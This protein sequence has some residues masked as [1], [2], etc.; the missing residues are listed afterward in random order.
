MRQPALVHG[1]QNQDQHH[2]FQERAD[3]ALSGLPEIAKGGEQM[4][5]EK[6]EWEQLCEAASQEHDPE[7]LMS[8]I[9]ELMKTL[10][11]RQSPPSKENS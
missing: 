8:L 1:L 4:S 2:N 7:K 11:E 3:P 5:V 10:D 6:Q 9:S